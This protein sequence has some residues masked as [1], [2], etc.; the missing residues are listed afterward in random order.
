M[1]VVT[2]AEKRRR[3]RQRAVA[4]LVGVVLLVV[5]LSIVV[6][7]TR[8]EPV[9]STTLCPQNRSLVSHTTVL[10]DITD[11]P[12][13]AHVAALVRGVARLKNEIGRNELLTI[14]LVGA[15]GQVAAK[16]VFMR[17]RPDDGSTVS[18]WWGNPDQ[19]QE[20]W[21]ASFGTPLA[22][23]LEQELLA[24]RETRWS[25]IFESVDMAM[26]DASF[27]ADLARRRMVIISDLMQNI[28][29]HSHYK[30]IPRIED[31]L[32]SEVGKRLKS[33]VWSSL[34]VDL[35]YLPD[36]RAPHLQGDKHIKFWVGVFRRLGV[37][38]VRVLPPF[39]ETDTVVR[40]H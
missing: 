19:V 14:R 26:W 23:V 1:A 17:C 33:K 21:Q 4:V 18:R 37:G 24:Q 15:D 25:A 13:P 36:V 27:G 40:K 28:P 29:G 7:A 6:A 39:E 11:F 38:S 32:A 31:F 2:R 10:V 22:Q 30:R 35:V 20:Q 34:T 5:G 12:T 8:P 16:P 3:E 9:D